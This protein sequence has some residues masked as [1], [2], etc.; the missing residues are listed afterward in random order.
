MRIRRGGEG[1]LRRDTAIPTRSHPLPLIPTRSHLFPPAPTYS[2][3]FP[4]IPTWLMSRLGS[5][6]MTVRPLKSTLFPDRLPR[7][8][9]CLPLSRCTKPL[10]GFRVEGLQV[11]VFQGFKFQG[12]RGSWLLPRRF[13]SVYGRGTSTEISSKALRTNQTGQRVGPDEKGQQR[14]HLRGLPVCWYCSGRP[15]RSELMSMAAW[16]WRAEEERQEEEQRRSGRKEGE[17]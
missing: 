9:P 8:R 17:E 6:L 13:M 4:L 2:H 15:G 1:K 3:P 12:F 14:P 7:K 11:S 16:I 10:R 5:G